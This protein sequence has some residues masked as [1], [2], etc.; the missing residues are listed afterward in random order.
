MRKSLACFLSLIISLSAFAQKH[1]KNDEIRAFIDC[2]T[3]CDMNYIKTEINFIDFV[4]D[5]F[6]AN[7]YVMVTSQATG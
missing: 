4:P 6:S 7:V 2:N 3:Y 5:R 1:S